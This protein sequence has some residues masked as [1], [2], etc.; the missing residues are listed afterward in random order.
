M[1]HLY[2]TEKLKFR[3]SDVLQGIVVFRDQGHLASLLPRKRY[4]ALSD[5][6]LEAAR[7]MELQ[8]AEDAELTRVMN[9][10]LAAT[11]E[12]SSQGHDHDDIMG[13]LEALTELPTATVARALT[14]VGY[15]VVV[16]E[17]I[18]YLSGAVEGRSG[19]L[20]LR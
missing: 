13:A 11:C 5:A 8:G 6:V 12:V 10:A 15:N 19:Y 16:I 14:A 2:I 3:T 4:A 20:R 18:R 7:A 1:A 9:L 17:G